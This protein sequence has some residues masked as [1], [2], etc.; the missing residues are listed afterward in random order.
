MLERTVKTLLF[1]ALSLLSLSQAQLVATRPGELLEVTPRGMVQPDEIRALAAPLF[2][3]YGVPRLSLPVETYD[4]RFSTTGLDGS[5]AE[6]SA[7]LFVPVYDSPAERPLYVFGSGTTGIAH[8]CAP[9]REAEYGHPFGHYRAYMMAYASRGF[10]G[11]LP[12][13]LDFD[14]PTRTQ[15][16][17]NALAEGRVMLDAARAARAFFERYPRAVSP[18]DAVFAAGYSQGGH[19]A[20]AAADLRSVYAPEVPL[21]GIIGYGATTNV[22]RLLR[23]G[24]YYAP[25]IVQS[26]ST[27]YGRERFDPARV[28]NRRWTPTLA[29]DVLARCVDQVQ[30]YYP[31]DGNLVYT[32]DFARSLYGDTL[33]ADFPDIHRILEENRTGLSGHS[34]PALLVQGE[35]DIIVRNATQERFVSELCAANSSVHYLRYPGVRHRFTRQIGFDES[36]AW[37]EGLSRGEVAPSVCSF[38]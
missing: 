16:Y 14:D 34:L 19:A 23:E 26:Y 10:I 28:L 29:A 8:K 4:L 31:S 30:T 15:P 1:A 20:F 27:T 9:S 12:N 37:M 38:F 24:P 25:Y 21:T 13:Y 18:S 36:I 7:Q 5:S 3:Q 2:A 6:V 32:S 11:I 35:N 22:E 33:A 17:F